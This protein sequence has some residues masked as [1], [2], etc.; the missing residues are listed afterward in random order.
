MQSALDDAHRFLEAAERAQETAE[1]SAVV[2]APSISPPW[3]SSFSLPSS[4]LCGEGATD[5]TRE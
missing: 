4:S 2:I 1:K 3:V 5:E